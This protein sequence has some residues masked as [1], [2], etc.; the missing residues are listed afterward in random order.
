MLIRRTNAR[1]PESAWMAISTRLLLRSTAVLACADAK[2]KPK[3][4]K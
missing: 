4:A 3:L 2:A 1:L